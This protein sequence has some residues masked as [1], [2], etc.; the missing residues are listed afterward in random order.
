MLENVQRRCTKMVPALRNMPYHERLRALGLPTLAY[1]RR[2]ADMV[3]VY[4]IMHGIDNVDASKFFSAAQTHNTRGH[5]KK[6]FKKRTRLR[7]RG[8]FFS[9]RTVNDWNSLPPDLAEAKTLNEFKS[10]L[11][12]HWSNLPCKFDDWSDKSRGAI[13]D[14]V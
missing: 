2:R 11:N 8:E 13:I 4:R 10:L 5:N 1:R 9:Q 7:L 3:Q 6:I 12:K 14:F